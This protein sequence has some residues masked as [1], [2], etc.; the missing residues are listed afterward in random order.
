MPKCYHHTVET[1]KRRA[2]NVKSFSAAD[3]PVLG[4]IWLS[5]LLT[6]LILLAL[7]CDPDVQSR[8]PWN[9]SP[10]PGPQTEGALTVYFLDVGQGDA[11]LLRSGAETMLIDGGPRENEDRLLADLEELGVD[12][13]D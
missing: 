6:V 4:R 1:W 13:L 5:L 12:H 3:G 8:L 2:K 11:A 9:R 10:A 7:L